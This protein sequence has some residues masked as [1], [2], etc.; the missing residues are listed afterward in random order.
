MGLFSECQKTQ[1]NSMAYIKYFRRTTELQ[2]IADF[3]ST[4]DIYM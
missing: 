4:G 1:Q 2:Y 3:T